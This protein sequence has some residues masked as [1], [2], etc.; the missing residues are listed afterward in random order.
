M[1]INEKIRN[2]EN[3]KKL[4]RYTYKITDIS[5]ASWPRTANTIRK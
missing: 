5:A 1:N 3:R 4:R 2:K